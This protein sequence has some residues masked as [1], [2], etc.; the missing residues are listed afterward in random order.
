MTFYRF[1]RTLNSRINNI[2]ESLESSNSRY[3]FKDS[4][5]SSPISNPF[6]SRKPKTIVWL[7]DEKK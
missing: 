2:Q 3:K 5:Y 7:D 1:L 6:F 4:R